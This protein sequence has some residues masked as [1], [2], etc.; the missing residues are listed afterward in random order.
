MDFDAVNAAMSAETNG[1][2]KI[3]MNWMM[4][5]F[6]SSLVFIAKFKTA[7]WAIATI[8]GTFLLAAIVWRLTHNV[9]LFAIPH[10]ILWPW[11]ALYLWRSTLSRRAKMINP[12]PDNLYS[13][14]HMLW[15]SLLFA[16]IIISLVFD[17]RDVFLVMTGGK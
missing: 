1:A 2:T 7:R 4:V 13:K 11:L 16:T 17:V 8:L 6:L 14:A 10:I 3:W 12:Y 5:M 9:H 15:A